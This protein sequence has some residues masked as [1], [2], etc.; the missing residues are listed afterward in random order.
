MT[1]E[2]IDH[3]E[4]FDL[5][6]KKLKEEDLHSAY[7]TAGFSVKLARSPTPF[8]LSTYLPTILLTLASFIGF[9]I[10]V[11]CVPGRMAPLVT[12]FLMLVNIKS[13]ERHVGPVVSVYIY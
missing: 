3:T 1:S 6:F 12:I 13:T 11:D 2:A 5:S 4:K 7:P 8:Y 9:V 10:P